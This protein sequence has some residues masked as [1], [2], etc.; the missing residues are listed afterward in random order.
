[1]DGQGNLVITARKETLPGSRCWYGTC[2]YT[3][4]RL[5]TNGKFSQTYGRFE[6]RMRLPS[7][8]GMWPAL[9]MLGT[10]SG[11]WPAT[12]EID[13]MENIG[14]LPNTVHGTIHGP[15]YS[16]SA[17]PTAQYTAPSPLSDDF[18]TYAIEWQ[19]NRISWFFDGIQYSTKTPADIGGNRWVFDHP[20]YL[21]MNLAVGGLW[22]GYPDASTVFP[23][24]FLID[25]V[26]V[27]SGTPGGSPPPPPVTSPPVTSP[28][29]TSPPPPPVT[30]PP[31]PPPVGGTTWAPGVA[32]A[33]GQVVTYNGVRYTCRQS[34]TSI[35]SW[36][37][38]NVPALWLP[39]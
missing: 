13:I 20:F 4:A 29:V 39:S 9:W 24:R 28:P 30:S 14:R 11:G 32:Y 21:L 31:P 12:G 26:R 2:Q 36:E 27:Y 25:Y 23:Q 22:P 35:V 33:V 7:G 8:Q 5:L 1:M 16:G 15:G 10:G 18:H 34:H 3:S 17:G 37:P 6:A 38:P 19:P